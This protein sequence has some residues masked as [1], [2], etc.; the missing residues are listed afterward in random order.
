MKKI[1]LLI[2][3]TFVCLIKVISQCNTLKWKCVEIGY[4]NP[5]TGNYDLLDGKQIN[6]LENPSIVFYNKCQN[7]SGYTYY[8]GDQ[9][10][11]KTYIC[12]FSSD[13]SL[14]FNW[15]MSN[16]P[17]LDSIESSAYY[18]DSTLEINWTSS[19]F[20]PI[21][22]QY[23]KS[24]YDLISYCKIITF[25]VAT[26]RDSIFSDSICIASSD[27]ATITFYYPDKIKEKSQFQL[28][29]YPNPTNDNLTIK[30]ENIPI[31]DVCLYN[32]MGQKVKQV[33]VNSN[34]T[35]LDVSTLPAGMYLVKI[36]TEQGVLTRK[37]QI[38]R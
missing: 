9:I 20:E 33:F 10:Y 11:I 35:T 13:G 16:R 30:N 8:K 14:G 29:L 7:V 28:F 31:K 5:I 36:N 25:I 12:P 32:I 17:L 37:V 6:P 23:G 15:I 18:N 34:E 38:I 1:V 21:E 22:N 2:I 4:I 19:V 3:L 27:T 24:W 26:N